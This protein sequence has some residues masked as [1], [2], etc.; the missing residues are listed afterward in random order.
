ME[1]PVKIASHLVSLSKS[2][3]TQFVG[4]LSHEQ[5]ESLDKALM[6]ALRIVTA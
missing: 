2:R 3:L 6:T 5:L 4:R 1:I